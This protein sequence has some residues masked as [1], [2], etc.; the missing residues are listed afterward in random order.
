MS[1]MAREVLG[2]G[3]PDREGTAAEFGDVVAAA[4]KRTSPAD[5]L[6]AAAMWALAGV[7]DSEDGGE[8]QRMW[9]KAGGFLAED[10]IAYQDSGD[11]RPEH[12][13]RAVM[14]GLEATSRQGVMTHFKAARQ[15]GVELGS[16]EEGLHAS[17]WN[18]TMIAVV[19]E[20]EGRDAVSV[21]AGTDDD[22]AAAALL[23]AA[24]EF[25]REQQ[26]E[27]QPKP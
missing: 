11:L 6:R 18:G 19:G 7:F 3:E 10:L 24:L 4:I 9:Q 16:W 2:E 8:Q 22:E 15:E 25:V 13:I 5:C 1:E 23:E 26:R 14:A 21:I 20:M 12:V 17:Y 27:G